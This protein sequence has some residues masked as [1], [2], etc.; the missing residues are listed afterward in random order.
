MIP[1]L[2]LALATPPERVPAPALPPDEAARREALARFGVGLLRDAADRPADAAKH[3]EAAAKAAPDSPAPLRPLVK[4]YADLGRDA[5]AIRTART[6][7]ELDPADAD[8]GHA[9]GKL[10]FDGKRFA[11]ATA[12]LK[13][14]ADSPRLADRPAKKLGLLRDLDRAAQLA[15]DFAAAADACLAAIALADSAREPLLKSGVFPAPADLDREAAEFHERLGK[16]LTARKQYADAAAAFAKAAALFADKAGDPGAAA[17]LNW[18]LSAALAEKGDAAAALDHLTKFLALKPSGTGPYERLVELLRKLGRGKDVAPWLDRLAAA[19][20]AHPGIPWVQ[21]YALGAA[22]PA[23]AD[24][25]FR[26]LLGRTADP[27]AHRL[28]V[29]HFR[30]TNRPAELLALVDSLLKAAKGKAAE[31]DESPA[32]PAADAAAVARARALVDAVK[33]DPD[34]AKLLVRHLP[35]IRP[36]GS[37]GRESWDVLAAL[38]EREGRLDLAEAALRAAAQGNPAARDVSLHLLEVLAKQRKWAKLRTECESLIERSPRGRSLMAD[39]YLAT[40]LAELGGAANALEAVKIANELADNV[41]ASGQLWAGLQKPRILNLLGK[42]ADAVSA[43]EQLLKQYPKPADARRIRVTLAD[44]LNGRKEFAKAEAELRAVLD[45]DPDDVLVLNNLGYNLADQ[46]RKLDEAET[47]VRRA[48]ELDAVERLRNGHAEAE[49]G[50]YLDSLGWVLFRRGKLADARAVLEKAV[51][52]PDSG[53]DAVVWDHL[54][55]VA[56]RQGDTARAKTAWTKAVELYADSHTGRQDGRRDETV[57]KLKR[58][59]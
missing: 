30:E 58:L 28:A 44:S 34:A 2:L 12:V 33:A 18:N 46:G 23:A 13:T 52:L 6:V 53:T 51:T 3:L 38:A 1:V 10:L 14:A 45:D 22:D 20:P 25:R 47:M 56:F 41:Q 48:I 24:R 49:S 54:G 55:D 8:T 11:E 36:A 9:L 31:D 50:V 43:C 37:I 35:S 17:R 16:A 40:A 15:G 27:A 7:L 21:A 39:V 42:H 19:D 5:A 4:V 29:R 57:R 32:K 26:D 59:P